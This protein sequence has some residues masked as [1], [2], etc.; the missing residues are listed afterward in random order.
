MLSK[1]VSQKLELHFEEKK[2][3]G[4]DHKACSRQGVSVGGWVAHVLPITLDPSS[5]H[6]LALQDP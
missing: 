1:A 6:R 5:S 4:V 3:G 2:R